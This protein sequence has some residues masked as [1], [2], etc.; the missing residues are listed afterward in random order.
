[1]EGRS[2]ETFRAAREFASNAPAEMV[3]QMPDMETAPAAP[4]AA[5][6]RFGRWDDVL[7][8]PGPPQEWLYTRGVWHYARGIALNA[9]GQAADAAR[10]LAA[11]EAL[12]KSVP[13]ERTTA[14]F[15]R[16]SN[17]L[18]MAA[19]VLAGEMAAKAGDAASAERLLRAAVA[20]QDTH[21]FTE[22]PPWYFPIRQ[23]LGAVLLQS[24]R[25]ADAELVY[26]EDL[27]RN[28]GNGWSLF[29]LA[30][31]L[32]AQ[33]KTAEAAQAEESFKK[34]WAQADVTLSASRF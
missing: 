24:G 15:F 25:P 34:A 4:I 32:R 2:A 21:W 6:V 29:G 16:S 23:T 28:P 10:E 3:K 33:G 27:R 11:L 22:P 13:P 14:F 20:E 19:N 17:L 1:M 5:L 30:Q 26:R 9:K 31:S 7:A 8:L 12:L 18:Q